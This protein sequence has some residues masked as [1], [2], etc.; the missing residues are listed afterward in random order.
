MHITQAVLVAVVASIAH[1]QT[2][3]KGFTP[4]TNS[5]LELFFNST[6]VTTPGQLLSKASASLQTLT[7]DPN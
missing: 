7:I 6:S 4:T 2:V 3:P 5:K 1:G